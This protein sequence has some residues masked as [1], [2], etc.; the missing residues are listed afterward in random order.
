MH[1]YKTQATA[2]RHIQNEE[3]FTRPEF[4]NFWRDKT[5]F[6]EALAQQPG[7]FWFVVSHNPELEWDADFI[8][9]LFMRLLRADTPLR[10]LRHIGP[11]L[12]P[13]ITES[14]EI[15]LK[16]AHIGSGSFKDY[17]KPDLAFDT[18]IR[19]AYA[20]LIGR[21]A[22]T[23][24]PSVVKLLKER[25]EVFIELVSKCPELFWT[26]P[27]ELQRNRDAC[28][29]ICAHEGNFRFAY[30]GLHDDEE[31]VLDVLKRA[32]VLDFND[33]FHTASY[34]IRKIFR[35]D[36]SFQNLEKYV[37]SKKLA[38]SLKEALPVQQ[39]RDFRVKI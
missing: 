18:D 24:D 11:Y 31:F 15:A 2:I 5:V 17:F 39:R 25:N 36:F 3:D 34:R 28:A 32:Q 21:T 19:R 23:L 29:S 35:D 4:Q 33:P 14:K 22:L 30:G 8:S 9:S 37:A 7:L 26:L 38:T 12:P 27:E 10:S 20:P 16:A 13:E 1:S 6:T